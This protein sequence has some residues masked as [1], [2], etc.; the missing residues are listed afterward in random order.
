MF[1][2]DDNYEA[3]IELTRILTRFMFKDIWRKQK[4]TVLGTD[5]SHIIAHGQ[6]HV[7]KKL[8]FFRSSYLPPPL[9][10]KHFKQ[11]E[12]YLHSVS[13]T[14]QTNLD[15]ES[16]LNAMD[17][18]YKS[19]FSSMEINEFTYAVTD[20]KY[21]MNLNK[22]LLECRYYKENAN[23]AILVALELQENCVFV[24]QIEQPLLFLRFKNGIRH[25]LNNEMILKL[26]QIFDE[27]YSTGR[28]IPTSRNSS[29]EYKFGTKYFKKIQIDEFIF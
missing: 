19:G 4:Y 25:F 24:K 3:I 6:F 17:N 9:T 27:F 5:I 21:D 11:H 28:Y 1:F 18:C 2:C 8:P 23:A 20:G 29:A 26:A 13:Q 22:F 10:Y 14:A 15:F 16:F 12:V 7:L